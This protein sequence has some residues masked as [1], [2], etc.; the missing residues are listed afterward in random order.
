MSRFFRLFPLLACAFLTFSQLEVPV[1]AA[2]PPNGQE[3]SVRPVH[4][5]VLVDESGSIDDAAMNS[6]KEAAG[7]IAL[8]EFA[9]ESTVAVVGFASDNGGGN[10]AVDPVCPVTK[11]ATPQDRESLAGC[12]QKLQKRAKGKDDGTDHATALSQALSDLDSAPRDEAKVVFL[13]TDGKLDV[14]DSPTYGKDNVG[15]RRNL[16]AQDAVRTQLARAN[17]ANVQVW[18]LGFGDKLDSAQLSEFAA[19][20]S[21]RTCGENSP[22]PDATVVG[23][24]G[25]VL[26]AMA[27]AYGSS[28]CAGGGVVS[29][30]PV[31]P[32]GTV[33]AKVDIPVIATDGSIIVFRRDP[34]I[35]VE[36]VDPQ[37]RTVPKSSSQG[38]S[39]FQ[40]SGGSGPVEA[41]RIVNPVPGRWT[42]KITA[43]DAVSSQSVGTTVLWQGAARAVL[44]VDPPAPSAGQEVVLGVRLQTRKNVIVDPVSLKGL[45]FSAR[46]SGKGFDPIA[47]PLADDGR[48]PDTAAG[49]G[50]YLGKVTIPASASGALVFTGGVS[51][52]GIQGDERSQNGVVA[53][54]VAQVRAQILLGPPAEPFVPPGGSRAGTLS[55][56]N[57]TGLLRKVRLVIADA[58][59]HTV[60]SVSPA[61]FELA[62]SGQSKFD[63]SLSFAEN[64]EVGIN[65]GTLQLVD[66]ANPATVWAASPFTVAVSYPPTL[67]QRLMWLWITLAVLLAAA[68][69]YLLLRMRARSRSRDVRGLTVQVSMGGKLFYLPAPD[70]PSAVFRFV[71]RERDGAVLIDPAS[72]ADVDAHELRRDGT[73]GVVLRKPDGAVVELRRDE[74]VD[75][76]PD[77]TLTFH[78]QRQVEPPP[79]P[80]RPVRVPVTEPAG[81]AAR[82]AEPPR[83]AAVDTHAGEDDLL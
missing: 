16:A 61:T 51:G 55:V 73:G 41:L 3:P 29:E 77:M 47:V 83:P 6:E 57:D 38:D 42:I 76:G 52:V 74:P 65:S 80:A 72:S 34:A 78:D 1:A 81:G 12:L 17:A 82:L 24:S 13:L 26:R 66:D 22:K 2:Q 19:G 68:L 11:V 49:D 67:L 60:A 62:A 40:V 10:S 14:S 32:G 79:K 56:T 43:P 31:K 37:G 50:L 9:P 21:Q 36:Y 70:E 33:E 15:N 64:T 18:P 39:T 30:T 45:T 5:V 48:K 23:G 63:F 35:T 44:S 71:V 28:R 20:G 69:V 75:I 25:D 27:K 54:G 59:P 46:L 58:G 7:L 8:G 53:G 4:L